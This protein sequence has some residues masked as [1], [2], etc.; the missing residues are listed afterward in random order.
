L[1]R[2]ALLVILTS[3]EDSTLAESFARK[4]DLISRH[5]LVLVNMPNPSS[6]RPLF[7]HP[8]R[9]RAMTSTATWRGICA[10]MNFW[11]CKRS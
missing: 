4:V 11:N 6:N 1:R 3:L 10:G 9:N 7:L 8:T 5:H 2:R